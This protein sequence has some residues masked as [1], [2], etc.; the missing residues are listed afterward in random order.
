MLT[1]KADGYDRAALATRTIQQWLRRASLFGLAVI[2]V[3]GGPAMAQSWRL[4]PTVQGNVMLTDNSRVGTNA[5]A[6]KDVV[7]GLTPGLKITGRGSQIR[8]DGDV[9]LRLVDYVKNSLD[10]SAFLRGRLGV[11]ADLIEHWL[12]LDTSISS[13]QTAMDPFSLRQGDTVSSEDL[14]TIRY[15]LSPYVERQLSSSL[16]FL[17]RS[18]NLWTRRSGDAAAGLSRRN[19]QVQQSV[20]RLERRPIPF[21]ASLELS[22]QRSTYPDDIDAA[23]DL[24]AL[25]A[26]AT[27][28]PVP[29]VVVGFLSGR[30]RSRFAL[31]NSTDTIYGGSLAWRPSERSDLNVRAEHRFFGWGGTAEVRHRSPFLALSIRLDRAPTAQPSSLLIGSG[32]GDVAALLDAAFTT[33]YPVAAERDVIVKNLIASRGLPSS[34]SGPLDVFPDYV[35]LRKQAAIS[36]SLLGRKTTITVAAYGGKSTQLL[37]EDAPY[38]PSPATDSDNRQYGITLDVNRRI[39]A[40]TTISAQVAETHI[41]GLG[42]R[43][44]DTSKE[45]MLT[46]GINHTLSPRTAVAA[47]VRR[48]LFNSTVNASSQESAAFF[49]SNHRF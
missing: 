33:R 29:E 45:S 13:D 1:T 10:D 41:D 38:I 43:I 5:P 2:V 24:E 40:V 12:H 32:S 6:A 35:Q 11:G 9:S 21:G 17:A 7:I 15:R 18:D 22:S 8:V 3:T 23:L 20:V 46:L 26:S 44:G 34:L 47:G 39:S 14:T 30:E 49:G 37:R 36:A 4:D 42:T 25:R 19:S 31:N 16:T 27:Y 28:A 48:R